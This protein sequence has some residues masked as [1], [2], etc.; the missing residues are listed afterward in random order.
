MMVSSY[1]KYLQDKNERIA[2][3]HAAE[4]EALKKAHDARVTE[5]LEA[6]NRMLEEARAA[7]AELRKMIDAIVPK[8]LRK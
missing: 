8:G 1:A 2:A 5:L 7:R 3:E 6:N 4:I